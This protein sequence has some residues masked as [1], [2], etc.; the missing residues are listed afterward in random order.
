M[1]EAQFTVTVNVEPRA[2]A[3]TDGT[4][5]AGLLVKA[6]EERRYTL[7]VAY[8]AD[9]PDAEIAAD[10]FR[11]FARKAVVEDAAWSYLTKSPNVGRWHADGTDG[12]GQV[13]ESY[14]YRGPDWTVTAADG[15]THV[16]K[17]GDWLMGIVWTPQS[18]DDVKSGRIGGVSMQ[19]SAVRRPASADALAGLRS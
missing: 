4:G 12:S 5:V 16:V 1:A 13:V 17:S 15:S 10:G 3:P 14:I 19:G 11:D 2:P 18:W 6:V 9:K 8:P 7:V